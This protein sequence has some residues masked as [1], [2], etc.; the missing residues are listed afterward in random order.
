[1]RNCINR[2]RHKYSLLRNYWN[3]NLHWRVILKVYSVNIHYC[4]YM[5]IASCRLY[6]RFCCSVLVILVF[7]VVVVVLRQDSNRSVMLQSDGF[8]LQYFLNIF[9]D[10]GNKLRYNLWR[11]VKNSSN[12]GEINYKRKKGSH[13]IISCYTWRSKSPSVREEIDIADQAKLVQ[14]KHC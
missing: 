12:K 13:R 10:S 3:S 4:L 14:S 1:M 2:R 11:G 8:V 9:N 6:V 7:I 5:I